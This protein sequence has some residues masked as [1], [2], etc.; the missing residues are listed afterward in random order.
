MGRTPTTRSRHCHRRRRLPS[1]TTATLSQGPSIIHF[2]AEGPLMEAGSIGGSR[3]WQKL[4]RVSGRP[5]RAS[6]SQQRLVRPALPRLESIH[7]FQSSLENPLSRRPPHHQD[8]N[9]MSSS[10]GVGMYLICALCRHAARRTRPAPARRQAMTS[11][12]IY[13]ILTSL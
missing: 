2:D 6:A 4:V 5:S 8:S 7:Q 10:Y 1:S 13:V 11:T 12:Q 9:G 3:R